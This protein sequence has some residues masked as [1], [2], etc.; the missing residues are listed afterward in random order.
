MSVV[1][2][3][4]SN[5][6]F[7]V[8]SLLTFIDEERTRMVKDDLVKKE[9]C[10]KFLTTYLHKLAAEE[11]SNDEMISKLTALYDSMQNVQ[12]QGDRFF[13]EEAKVETMIPDISTSAPIPIEVDKVADFICSRL[14]K[15]AYSLGSDGNHVMAFE[16]ERVIRKI[17]EEK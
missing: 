6:N 13:E 8:K 14:E 16:V 17:N 10:D 4:L 12:L 3:L 1:H 11:V 2:G 7:I 9:S 5:K 15:L